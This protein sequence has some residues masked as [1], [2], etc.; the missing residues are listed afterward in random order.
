MQMVWP[1]I[2]LGWIKSKYLPP[3]AKKQG[4]G[5]SYV[6]PVGGAGEEEVAWL[7]PGS[8]IAYGAPISPGEECC[9]FWGQR[10]L[11][12]L[13]FS[14]NLR[15]WMKWEILMTSLSIEMLIFP[16]TEGMY[17]GS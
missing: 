6:N 14:S 7:R 15:T 5:R 3:Q 11:E 10:F 4:I 16:R 17:Q 9:K 8:C 2:S 13:L 1:F 12:C